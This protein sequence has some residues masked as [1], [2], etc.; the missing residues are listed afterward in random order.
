MA[1]MMAAWFLC[2][3]CADAAVIAGEL[4]YAFDLGTFE[5]VVLFSSVGRA[6]SLSWEDDGGVISIVVFG[7]TTCR[8]L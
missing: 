4:G 1:L 6:R 5:R 8:G 3:F 2:S 7:R